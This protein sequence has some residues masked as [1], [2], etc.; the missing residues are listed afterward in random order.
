MVPLCLH[1]RLISCNPLLCLYLIALLFMVYIVITI[2]LSGT[3]PRHTLHNRLITVLVS[4]GC[5][6]KF[7]PTAQLKTTAL[8]PSTNME[9][10]SKT[11]TTE[12]IPRH[13]QR[14]AA[15]RLQ[16]EPLS[17]LPALL[18]ATFLGLSPHHAGLQDQRFHDRSL[19]APP[20]LAASEGGGACAPGPSPQLE[21]LNHTT[22]TPFPIQAKPGNACVSVCLCV[23]KERVEAIILPTTGAFPLLLSQSLYYFVRHSTSTYSKQQNTSFLL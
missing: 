18:A 19:P 8:Y 6:N 12:W 15:H 7:P 22:Q 13:W 23:G 4:C 17:V 11:R 3:A 9:A 1:F 2:Y 21:S 16:E 5:C 14:H 20:P 10:D